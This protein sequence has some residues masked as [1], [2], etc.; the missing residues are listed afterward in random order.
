MVGDG[1]HILFWHDRW[2]GDTS[3]K[4]IYLQLYA[5]SN[6]KEACISDQ[7]GGNNRF[8]NLRF[9]RNF[10]ERELEAAFSF[11]DFIQSRIPRGIGCDSPHWC[12]KGM[13]SSI[14]SPFII[15]SEVPLSLASLGRGFGKSR[16]QKWWLSSCG[17]Q[18]MV[19]YLPWII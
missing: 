19:G 15:R 7:E 8:W 5:C 2:I 1:S 11:L 4:M 16:F 6:D 14:F 13:V 12:L 10:H 3:L 9:Y 17:P 18:L